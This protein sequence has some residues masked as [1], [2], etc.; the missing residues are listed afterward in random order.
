[1]RKE[2]H[3]KILIIGELFGIRLQ[4]AQNSNKNLFRDGG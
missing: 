4:L 2:T 3:I 1:M